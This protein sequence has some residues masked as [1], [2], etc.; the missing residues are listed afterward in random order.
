MKAVI[1]EYK[2]PLVAMLKADSVKDGTVLL[3]K[4]LKEISE[5]ILASMP[6]ETLKCELISTREIEIPDDTALEDI[7]IEDKIKIESDIP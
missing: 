2:L 3:A 6:L 1:I 7:E 4:G 5:A